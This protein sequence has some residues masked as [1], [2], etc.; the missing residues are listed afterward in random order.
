MCTKRFR[1]CKIM[2]LRNKTFQFCQHDMFI[3]GSQTLLHK[4]LT[5]FSLIKFKF[6]FPILC[7]GSICWKTRTKSFQ[8]QR[9]LINLFIYLNLESKY[10]PHRFLKIV[11]ADV[12]VFIMIHL[13]Q[14]NVNNVL[15]QHISCKT[16]CLI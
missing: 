3:L 2:I 12:T 16:M 1:W 10:K 15:I 4:T 6:K 9:L 5:I 11:E 7:L 8:K 14:N 13:S